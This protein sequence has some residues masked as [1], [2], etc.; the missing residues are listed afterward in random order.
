MAQR[1]QT[2][3]DAR[4]VLELSPLDFLGGGRDEPASDPAFYVEPPPR[5]EAADG[6]PGPGPERR[7]RDELLGRRLPT[8]L[9]LSGHVGSGKSTQINKLAADE[10]VRAAFSVLL[11]RVEAE[12]IPFLDA[13]QL[14]FLIAASIFD[15]GAREKLL[16]EDAKWKGV[17]RDLDAQLFGQAGVTAK[18]G[19]LSA[20]LNLFFVKL[21]QDLRLS[22]SRREEFRKLGETQR[23]I[24]LDLVKSLTLD[25]LGRLKEQAR[26]HSL[27]LLIDDLDKVRGPEQ[28]AD[29]FHTNLGSLLTLPFHVLYTVPTG[30]VFG[31]NRVEL[32]TYR[33]HLYPVRVLDKSSG[34]DPERAFIPGSDAFFRSALDRRV[35]PRLFDDAAVR[36][37]A[38]YAGG[39]LREF[40]RFLRTAV[41]LA[42]YNQLDV[43]DERAVRAAVRDER[44]RETMGLYAPDY[45][46]LASIHRAHVMPQD[47]DRRY[48]DESRVI[49]CYNGDTWYEVNPLLWKVLE[50]RE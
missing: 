35:E 2:L 47:E 25:V 33:E 17:L 42:R 44:R 1:A 8:A 26:H 43:V 23:S 15:F 22:A 48:L 16:S 3:D 32:R 14:L 31:P 46:A 30:V 19:A 37:A 34:F 29:I 39:V 24:L 50:S 6:L 20:E 28:Q 10:A 36:L 41:G 27:L 12:M 21:R 45:L 7:L 11:L 13:S 49:E 5:D 38:I 18:E 4:D 9:F 40:F